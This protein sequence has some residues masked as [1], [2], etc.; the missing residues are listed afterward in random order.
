MQTGDELGTESLGTADMR[1]KALE[2]S[3]GLHSVHDDL[4]RLGAPQ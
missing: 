1:R 3:P 4:Q 2:L